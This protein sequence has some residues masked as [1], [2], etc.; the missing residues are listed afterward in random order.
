M[1]TLYKKIILGCA[2]L[3]TLDGFAQEA[4]LLIGTY[5]QKGSK[6]IYVYHFD[7]ATGKSIELSHTNNISNPSFLAIT[8][9]KQNV[10]AVN[11]DVEGGITS[12]SFKNN[13]LKTLQQLP[14]KGAHPCYITISPDQKNIFVA[15]YTGG[16]I[17]QFYRFAD[18]TISNARLIIQH[19]GASINKERQEKAHV[20]GAFFNPEGN[21]LFTPDLGMDQITA[22]PYKANANPVL[23]ADKPIILNATPGSGPRHM[24]FSKNGKLIYVIEELTGTVSVYQIQ[25]GVSKK[26]QTV[27]THSANFNGQAGSADVHLSPDEK[28]LY[29]SNRGNENNITKLTILENGLINPEKNNY[30]SSK[31]MKPR[32][33]TISTDGKWLLVANQD[34]DNIAVYKI[35]PTNGDLI[36]TGNE[37]KV[38]MPVCLLLF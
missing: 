25:K 26:V 6:G 19:K 4:N 30:Y 23:Q 18:G 2:L 33:F 28:Y 3:V 32:N 37:I 12:F 38:S 11:E 31:G 13:T 36:D 22:Y 7:T 20:H 29:V 14:S 1:H 9:D 24:S 15:N 17:A 21:Y 16:N 8:K 5:T 34:S 27:A 35:N 10:Y